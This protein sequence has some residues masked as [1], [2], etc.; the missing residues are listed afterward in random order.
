MNEKI[1]AVLSVTGGDKFINT[2]KQ[3]SD[4]INRFGSNAEKVGGVTSGITSKI[5]SLVGA[6][7]KITAVVGIGK[8]ISGAFNMIR[9]SVGSA[10]DR[11][12]TLN[13]FPLMMQAMGFSAEDSEKSI[14]KLSAGIEGLPTPLDEVVATAQGIAIMTGDLDSATATT[15]ALNNAF[16]ASG[17]SSADASRGLQQYT[18]MLGRGEVDLQSWRTLQ[19]TMGVALNDIAKSF[20]FAGESAQTDLY[21]ALKSGE[22][23]MDQFNSKLVEMD[24]T[25]NGFADRAKIA[26]Q[27]IKTSFQNVRTAVVKNVAN[28]IQAVDDAMQANGFGSIAD[29]LNRVKDLVNV[30]FGAIIQLIPPVMQAIVGLYNTIKDSTAFQSFVE[31]VGLVI[32]KF[33]E[34]ASAF[35]ESSAFDTIKNAIKGV[36]DAVLAIDFVEVIQ[37]VGDFIDKWGPLIAGIGG[38]ILA[39]QALSTIIPIVVGVFKGFAILKTLV[40]TVGLVQ[41]AFTLLAPVIMAI[42]WPLV[43]IAAVI[44]AVVAAGVLLYKNWETISAKAQEIWGAIVAFFT[45][46]GNRIST[47]FQKDWTDIKEKASMAWTAM[48]EFFSMVWSGIVDMAKAIWGSIST[49]FSNLW[50]SITT[51]AQAA[52]T[53]FVGILSGIWSG[54]LG[55][56]TAIFNGI[57]TFLSTVW[58]GI[59]VVASVAWNAIVNTI[60]V[61]IGALYFLLRG[62]VNLVIT[63]IT[64]AWDFIKTTTATVW[65]IIVTTVTTLATSLWNIITNIFNTI[66][67]TATNVWTAI[68]SVISTAWN[69]IYTTVSGWLEQV[70]S[71]VLTVFNAVKAYVTTVWN[72]ITSVIATVWNTIYSKVSDWIQKVKTIIT[73]VFN[74]I[75]A[76]ITTVWNAIK[77]VIQ[78][79]WN[80]VYT[81][82]SNAVNKVRTVIL[83]VFNAVRTF[84]NTVFNTIKSTI[85][86]AWNTIYSVVSSAVNKV[87]SI[88]T[89]VFNSVKSTVSN[90]WNTI[91][92]TTSS[93]WSSIRSSISNTLNSIKSTMSNIF[94]SLRGIVSSAFNNVVSAV[95]NGMTSAYNAVK[96]KLSQFKNAGRNIVTS[97]ADGIKGAVGKVTDAIGNVVQKVR[98]FLPFSPAKTGPLEDL[99]KLN[100]GGTISDSIYGGQRK[101]QNAMNRVMQ[102]PEVPSFETGIHQASRQLET[103]IDYN[104]GYKEPSKQPAEINLSIG[105]RTFRA[106]VADISNAQGEETDLDLAF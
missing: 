95:R 81:V 90:V 11:V 83:N 3:A 67:I 26:S 46:V 97:I 14:S 82:V 74:A 45:E 34:M 38:A 87:R 32:G 69:A 42:N 78:T 94:N 75:K 21:D 16:L 59:K 77:N 54:I 60:Y 31:A 36:V 37:Q 63:L 91:K 6:F 17:S 80:Q 105:G 57:A 50:T 73:N 62:P 86:T 29:N 19:E 53:G 79:V 103:E 96:N 58:E 64:T 28:M 24:T 52:W 68:T 70:R 23:T 4:S 47:Q 25:T 100:F 2:F 43:A 99:N 40:G 101:I 5:G 92:S 27:G 72:S 85:T 10:V 93:I 102:L 33:R 22:I 104:V 76:T 71:V 12:D 66:K 30:A 84:I 15:L 49:F 65:N 89:S 51:G 9:D 55:L 41:T 8:L 61:V 1:E 88:V 48:S 39:F 44:G 7:G 13:R 20:G 98:D 106:F 56:A 35:M 18:Q